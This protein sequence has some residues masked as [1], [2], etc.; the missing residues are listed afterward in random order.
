MPQATE[1]TLKQLAR[2]ARLSLSGEQ[3][4]LFARQL[5]QILD[6]ARSIQ[7]LDLDQGLA[8]SHAATAAVFREDRAVPGLD[9]ATVLEGAPDAGEG[10]FRVPRV[11]G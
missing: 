11:F 2:L 4:A 7:S 9:R 1:E 3:T 5:D 8:R 6:Y 10:L